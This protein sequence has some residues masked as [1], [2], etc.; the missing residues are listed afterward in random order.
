MRPEF[1]VKV[2]LQHW[3][4][5]FCCLWL[6]LCRAFYFC[7]GGHV[8]VIVCLL[9]TLRKTSKRICMKFSGKVGKEPVNN[10]L[11]F[12]GDPDHRLD[13]GIVFRIRHCWEIGKAWLRCSY[14]IITS[15]AHDSVTVTALHTATLHAACSVTGARY[16]ETGKTGLGGGMH[17]PS[18]SSF[19]KSNLHGAEIKLQLPQRP[20]W[21]SRT[22][23][24][25]S[26]PFP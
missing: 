16:H 22:S 4:S 24:L 10:W 11:N 21:R 2:H 6:T 23:Q 12:G 3:L 9:A 13:T 17:C 1:T 14:D 18:P 7:Q 25:L 20:T 15:M 26:E 5:C 19:L 8:F